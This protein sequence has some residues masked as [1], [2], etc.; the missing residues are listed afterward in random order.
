MRPAINVQHVSKRYLIQHGA[1]AGS[2]KE[3]VEHYRRLLTRKFIPNFK[4]GQTDPFEVTS[5]EFWALKD[6][7]F[8]IPKG[9][10]LGI[11]GLNG[12]G[13]STLLKIL[14]Q[15][16]KP[17]EGRIEILGRISSL[18]EMGTGFHAEL[19]GRENIFLNGA[20]LG[21][22]RTEITRKFDEIVAFSEL[23]RFIDTPFKRYSS[24]MQ[25]RLGFAVA[26]H[27]EPDILILD[28]VLAVGDVKFQ[29][30]CLQKM[31]E[32]SNSGA[33]IIFVNHGVDAIKQFC[34]HAIVLHQGELILD[35]NDIDEAIKLYLGEE[36]ASVTEKGLPI[37]FGQNSLNNERYLE[38][39]WYDA[40]ESWGVWS[41]HSEAQIRLPLP[42]PPPKSIGFLVNAF[43]TE[44]LPMQRVEIELNGHAQKTVE[45]RAVDDNRFTVSIPYAMQ[46]E[47]TIEIT[48]RFL[49]AVSPAE[50]GLNDDARTL[51][52]GLKEIRFQ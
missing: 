49:D 52:V 23:E 11:L 18:L 22:G 7:S 34:N 40:N 10:K 13:K 45:L 14:S 12:A 32:I 16:T 15:V 44:A 31:E 9:D 25:A 43:V 26:A 5:E 27:L 36:K 48:L 29:K 37:R 1:Q 33:T 39:G 46:Q 28:E 42:N 3:L 35:T 2:L 17:T 24:G 4:A 21:M 41:A 38:F 47:K 50:L 20:L 8:K 30:K 6:V 51:A 19:S